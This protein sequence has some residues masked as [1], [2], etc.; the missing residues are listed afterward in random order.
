MP[1]G[2]NIRMCSLLAESVRRHHVPTTYSL[3]KRTISQLRLAMFVRE[4]RVA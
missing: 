1:S 3:T 4:G 2:A